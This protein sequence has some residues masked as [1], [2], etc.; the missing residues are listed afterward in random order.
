MRGEKV[1]RV[2]SFNHNPDKYIYLYLSR[3]S[4]S[5]G[6]TKK[7]LTKVT[8]QLLN[9]SFG[10]GTARLLTWFMLLDFDEEYQK[11]SESN[12]RRPR[13]RSSAAR[14]A[15]VTSRRYRDISRN[16]DICI[17]IVHLPGMKIVCLI[18]LLHSGAAR[19]RSEGQTLTRAIK[20]RKSKVRKLKKNIPII[21]TKSLYL[22][23]PEN[24]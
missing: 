7:A 5:N 6:R 19:R 21:R 22:F 14:P 8:S 3:S 1:N 12:W 17:H 24:K 15:P 4:S 11:I 10:E 20:G 9:L 13:Y 23:G 2:F 16:S 18:L